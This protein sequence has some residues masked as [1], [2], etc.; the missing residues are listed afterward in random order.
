MTAGARKE[1]CIE[2]SLSILY[3]HEEETHNSYTQNILAKWQDSVIPLMLQ[4]K[5][6]QITKSR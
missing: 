5:G 3:L 6:N 1:W 4:G 2:L